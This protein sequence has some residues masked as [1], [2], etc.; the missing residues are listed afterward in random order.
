MP[1]GG[2]AHGARSVIV[3]RAAKITRPEESGIFCNE[4]YVTPIPRRQS[5]FRL[6]S[7]LPQPRF[8]R[9]LLTSMRSGIRLRTAM[10]LTRQL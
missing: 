8:P 1:M 4:C 6:R 10:R 2:G 3:N 7:L 9:A 5:V